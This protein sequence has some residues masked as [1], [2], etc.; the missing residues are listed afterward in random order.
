MSSLLGP[1]A[2]SAKMPTSPVGKLGIREVAAVSTMPRAG[3]LLTLL[4]TRRH[5]DLGRTSSSICHA[6]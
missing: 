2:L 6:S 3:R 4:T 5:I 1:M